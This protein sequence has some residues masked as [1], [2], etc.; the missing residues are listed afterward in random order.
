MNKYV[1]VSRGAKERVFAER[2]TN[3]FGDSLNFFVGSEILASF[4]EWDYVIKRED[5]T[6]DD[7]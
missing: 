4:R 3:D 1:V 6:N 7:R 5:D 2:F